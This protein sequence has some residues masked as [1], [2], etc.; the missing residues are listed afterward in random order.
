MLNLPLISRGDSMSLPLII[1]QGPRSLSHSSK[2]QRTLKQ[3]AF[4]EIYTCLT[5]NLTQLI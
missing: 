2:V 1:T 4:S 5:A 3:K